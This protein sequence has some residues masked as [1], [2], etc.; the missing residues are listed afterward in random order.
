MKKETLRGIVRFL[1]RTL[2]RVEYHHLDNIPASG[3]VLLTT[4]HLSF[5]DT[6]LLFVNPIRT[7]ITALVA[8][9]YQHDT[10]MRWFTITAGGIWID[11]DRADF[12]ALSMARE[13]LSQGMVL[14]I[15]PEGTRSK[16]AQLLEGKPGTVLIALRTGVPILPVGISGSEGS[17]KRMFTLRQPHLT[18][19]VG[20]PYTIPPLERGN[21]DELLKHWTDEVM[22]RIAALLPEKYHG[23]YRGNPRIQELQALQ[24]DDPK[25]FRL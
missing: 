15:A 8:D 10:L 6:P 3:P 16:T 19:R 20:Q 25:P 24:A 21:R 23:F 13:V 14:G 12:A 7:D 11:R 18:V 17:V 22:L 2:A 9:K 5:V 1:L 4:N